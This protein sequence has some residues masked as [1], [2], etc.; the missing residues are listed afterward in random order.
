MTL[1]FAPTVEDLTALY[2]EVPANM[3]MAGLGNHAFLA[4]DDEDDESFE[5]DED[6]DAESEDGDDEDDEE[7][8][9]E[10]DEDEDEDEE[11]DDADED[12]AGEGDA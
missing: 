1:A 11:D 2:F 10:E 4:E 5:T 6:T 12:D 3:S 7:D 9:D 8:G